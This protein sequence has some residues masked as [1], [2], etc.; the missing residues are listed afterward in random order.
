M[1][2]HSTD[3]DEDHNRYDYCDNSANIEMC[4]VEHLWT[5]RCPYSAQA[6]NHHQASE[7]LDSK[8]D[9][10]KVFLDFEV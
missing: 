4:L 1:Q 5:Q 2:L 8:S 7:Y 6:V 9:S 10:P 3:S